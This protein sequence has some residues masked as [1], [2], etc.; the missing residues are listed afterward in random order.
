MNYV[1]IV[2]HDVHP[3]QLEAA[4]QRV[5]GNGRRMA[6]QSGFKSRYLMQPADHSERLV[7]VTI[8]DSK[9]AYDAWTAYNKANNPN[10][11]Q[12]APFDS[13][14]TVLYELRSQM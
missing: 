7:T 12:P 8:W 13:P 14:S 6:E 11:G 2:S 5:D 1:A 4:Q 10:A 3:G 9:A